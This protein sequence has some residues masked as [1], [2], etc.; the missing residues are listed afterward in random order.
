M[1]VP[2]RREESTH[3]S[4]VEPLFGLGRRRPR[5][6]RDARA[7][8]VPQRREERVH[9]HERVGVGLGCGD[10]PLVVVPRT[11]RRG[12]GASARSAERGAGVRRVRRA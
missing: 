12:Q 10:G 6:S 8:V 3:A 9:V 2:Q 4:Q 11:R 1:R 7:L 5:A